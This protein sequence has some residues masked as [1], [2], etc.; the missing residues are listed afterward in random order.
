[1]RRTPS[2][3]IP[4]HIGWNSGDVNDS[5]QWVSASAPVAAVS[6]GGR[7]TVSSGSRMASLA[8]SAGWKK[9]ALWPSTTMTELRP[10]SLPVP[11]V[12]G[13]VTQGAS[14]RGLGGGLN[15]RSETSGQLTR[16]RTSLPTSSALPP[17]SATTESHPPA[18]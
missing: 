3:A 13:T 1:M 5:M 4:S 8:S 6:L 7:P 9:T 15:R 14:G 17:P 2:S 18:R 12:V 10:T 16:T 11:A